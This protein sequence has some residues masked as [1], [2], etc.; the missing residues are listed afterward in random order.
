M[1][2]LGAIIAGSQQA[3]QRDIGCAG[4][5]CNSGLYLVL[6]VASLETAALS[7]PS[8]RDVPPIRPK[9]RMR[10]SVTLQGRMIHN[11][12]SVLQL[13]AAKSTEK[14]SGPE[15]NKAFCA[16]GPP[17]PPPFACHHNT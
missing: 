17:A 7:A 11:S 9:L 3:G 2:W 8:A 6:P 10:D 5:K 4:N 15:L 16:N 14:I 1:G 13:I 12:N